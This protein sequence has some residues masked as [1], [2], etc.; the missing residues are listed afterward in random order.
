MTTFK[1]MCIKHTRVVDSE[2]HCQ[3]LRR[4]KEYITSDVDDDKTV[5]VFSTYWVRFPVE[6]FAHE[7]LFTGGVANG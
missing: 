3:E 1:R 4:G 6:L 5:M 7:R 2:D